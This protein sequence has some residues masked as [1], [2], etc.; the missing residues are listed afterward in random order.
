MPH[1]LYLHSALVQTR[2]LQRNPEGIKK[3]I[4]YNNWDSGIAL[5]LALL[6]NAAILI[7]AAS[8][9]HKGG[10]AE[11]ASL[12]DAHRLLHTMLGQ[13]WSSHLFAI[14]LI[15]AGQSSTVTGTLAGQIVME[16]YLSL[17]INPWMRRLLTRLMAA[18]PAALVIWIAGESE[19]DN[20]LVFSQVLLSM[21]LAFAV[22]PL[23]HFVSSKRRM[24]AFAIGPVV[25]FFAW[26]VAAIIVV[27][28]VKLVV[29]E[30]LDLIT[31]HPAFWVTA[32]V[33]IVGIFY[34]LLKE[35]RGTR[36]G[37]HKQPAPVVISGKEGFDVIAVALD[38]S[39][40]DAQVMQYALQLANSSTRFVLI[41]VL[42]SAAARHMGANT[43]DLE[44]VED[45]QRLIDYA[46]QIQA[47]GFEAKAIL[48]Y[49]YRSREIARVVQEEKAELLVMGS[50]G[51]TT[52]L[53]WLFGETINSVR[54]M[55]KVPVFIVR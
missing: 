32:T 47:K 36:A 14:A 20:L 37:M 55:V 39:V 42:E 34:P 50:H 25:K 40:Y 16:G 22:I 53:D 51:H 28:N 13:E 44:A 45:R 5:N 33:L 35:Y 19:V 17:R 24:G 41:H 21:Q 38:Y 43:E 29:D 11:V 1:N 8:V 27:L 7:L 15:A 4:R 23:I 2:K 10:H 3:A 52:L 26:L 30:A 46:A 48:G 31:K 18:V 49:R 12:K 9:F 54:H 6:V